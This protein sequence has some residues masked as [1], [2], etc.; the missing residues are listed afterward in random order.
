MNVNQY[1]T[2]LRA[3]GYR[4]HVTQDPVTGKRGILTLFP[5]K[6]ASARIEARILE[7]EA[8]RKANIT[9]DRLAK[10]ILA[11]EFSKPDNKETRHG[12]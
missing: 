11:S 10:A 12:K 4:L 8:W 2:E 9:K 5:D 6:P 1:L 7:L 3:A